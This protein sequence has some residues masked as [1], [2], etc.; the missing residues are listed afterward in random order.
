MTRMLTPHIT[1]A[2][3]LLLFA[4]TGFA[5]GSGGSPSVG[6]YDQAA[7]QLSPEEASRKR[8]RA[9]VR[10]RDKAL[11]HER[12]AATAKND[13]AR[14]KQLKRAR[15]AFEKAIA[16]QGEALQLDPQNYAAANE[17]GFALR[18]TGEYRKAIGAY[19]YALD[20][21]PDFHE[22]T[23]YRGEAFLALGMLEQAQRSY[24][25]LF[26]DN[27]EL[28]ALLMEKMDAWLAARPEE[29]TQTE[30]AFAAWV[31]ER[32]RLATMTQD[33]SMRDGRDW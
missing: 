18:K 24:M 27:A 3:V 10:Q 16:K 31:A 30:Q 15:K 17:L 11:K 32:K 21:N 2:A 33:V 12:R 14:D 6:T 9:G 19:N 8:F 1:L 28:A 13:K 20:L 29:L 4:G 7:E 23:E 25:V 5:A 26:R 22:A